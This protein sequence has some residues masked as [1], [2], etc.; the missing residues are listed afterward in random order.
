MGAN[1]KIGTVVS[2]CM[3]KTCIVEVRER[4]LHKKYIKPITKRKRYPVHFENE[5]PKKGSLV[6]IRKTRP[7]SK[8]KSWILVQKVHIYHRILDK[9][10][11]V[12]Y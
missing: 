4:F 6:E 1:Y 8:T 11:L 7:I 3:Q 5:I 12:Y 2:V 9:V 10:L